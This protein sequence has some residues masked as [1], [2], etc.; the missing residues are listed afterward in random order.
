MNRSN[1]V[2]IPQGQVLNTHFLPL[3]SV[4]SRLDPMGFILLGGVLCC[5][6]NLSF[7]R[8]FL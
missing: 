5:L 2:G 1:F 6:A 3:G 7:G 4:Y 8:R